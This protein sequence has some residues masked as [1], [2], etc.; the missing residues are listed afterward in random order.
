MSI[1]ELQVAVAEMELA[2]GFEADSLL[3][4]TLLLL[5]EVGELS[6]TVRAVIGVPMDLEARGVSVEDELADVAI[7]LCAIA[8]RLQV[9]LADAIATKL[10]QDGRRRWSQRPTE[11]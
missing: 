2:R 5:E 4:K 6:K 10:D 7:V 3:E 11:T 9:G 1:V 8:N